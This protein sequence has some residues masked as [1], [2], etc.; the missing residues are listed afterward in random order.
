[1]VG[2]RF[3]QYAQGIELAGYHLHFVDAERRRGGHVLTCR[4]GRVEV[5][6][7]PRPRPPRRAATRDRAR[8][9]RRGRRRGRADPEGRGRELRSSR[10]GYARRCRVALPFAAMRAGVTR[11]AF[12]G[13]KRAGGCG[14]RGGRPGAGV[15]GRAP[16]AGPGWDLAPGRAALPLLLLPRRLV[17]RGRQHG[18]RG[19]LHGRAAGPGQ[20]RRG[21]L[22][23]AALL[24]VTDHNDVRSVPDLPSSAQGL[25]AIPGYEHSLHGHAQMLG[26]E[27]MYDPGDQAA[28]AIVAMA[29]ALR[30][31]G[32]VFQANHPAYRLGPDEPGCQGG[33][34]DCRAMNWQYGF[35]V[36]PD[37]VEVWNPSVSRGEVRRTT[38]SAGSSGASG[39][40]PPEAATRTGC[41]W[42]RSRGPGSPPRGY[43]A[44][45]ATVAR[46]ARGACAPGARRSPASRRL[47][48]A[49]G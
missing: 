10:P 32:G 24:A 31:D 2:F 37:T 33:C 43:Y 22:A 41:R 7:R 40:P 9:A 8:R 11:R 28:D 12:L 34:A 19:D 15:R 25:I 27:R 30:A 14:H 21:A 29:A 20:V 49:C 6:D 5:R 26:A 48:A 3:P 18:P 36:R 4:T 16:H 39:S 35:D 1:M 46:C 45:D 13:P 38:G 42:P 23:R 47:S 44:R 17:R